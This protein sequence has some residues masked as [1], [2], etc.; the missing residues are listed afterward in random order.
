MDVKTSY[1]TF[2]SLLRGRERRFRGFLRSLDARR[3]ATLAE[4]LEDPD[5]ALARIRAPWLDRDIFR[6]RIVSTARFFTKIFPKDDPRRNQDARGY[7]GTPLSFFQASP[8][9]EDEA[10]FRD[11]CETHDFYREQCGHLPPEQHY[12]HVNTSFTGELLGRRGSRR[13]RPGRAF[14]SFG[15][16]FGVGPRNAAWRKKPMV[17]GYRIPDY[18]RMLGVRPEIAT[19]YLARI[20]VHDI[21]HA[22]LPDVPDEREELHNAVMIRA[23]GTPGWKAP[24]A[25]DWERLI[26]AEC[27]DPHFAVCAD[28]HLKKL[29]AAMLTPLQR[30]LLE[31]YRELYDSDLA[32]KRRPALWGIDQS[33]DL[34]DRWLRVNFTLDEVCAERFARY[35][36]PTG[37]VSV[38][39]TTA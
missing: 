32:W 16:D 31:K 30:H 5:H 15:I 12:L 21:G 13:I 9:E 11:R 18:P 28:L 7:A 25:S 6:N 36:A 22:M 35:N 4:L 19:E 33:A 20:V 29:A 17:I 24:D 2:L 27:T 38:R 8:S 23:M 14:T 10:E 34:S 37:L 26:I 39:A 3:T 1:G